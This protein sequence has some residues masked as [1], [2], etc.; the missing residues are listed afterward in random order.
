VIGIG[1]EDIPRVFGKR[2]LGREQRNVCGK[3]RCCPAI[4][5]KHD[6]HERA[7]RGE[8]SSDHLVAAQAPHPSDHSVRPKTTADVACRSITVEPDANTGDCFQPVT[9]R[10]LVAV[11]ILGVSAEECV[12]FLGV[13]TFNQTVAGRHGCAER[14]KRC[15]PRQAARQASRQAG[16]RIRSRTRF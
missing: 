6:S 5:L 13:R 8:N 7:I 12:T 15:E 14:A 4:A 16:I 11:P 10:W 9:V 3:I 1:D 2:S